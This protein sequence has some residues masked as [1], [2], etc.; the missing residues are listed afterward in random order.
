[1]CFSTNQ[2][3]SDVSNIETFAA[4]AARW[5]DKPSAAGHLHTFQPH[6]EVQNIPLCCFSF[7]IRTTTKKNKK[8]KSPKNENDDPSGFEGREPFFSVKNETTVIRFWFW[9]VFATEVTEFNIHADPEAASEVFARWGERFGGTKPSTFRSAILIGRGRGYIE[10]NL[11]GLVIFSGIWNLIIDLQIDNWKKHRCI[12]WFDT[13]NIR[14]MVGHGWSTRE[15]GTSK[16]RWNETEANS[17]KAFFAK[18]REDNSK[19][20]PFIWLRFRHS[21]SPHCSS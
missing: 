12:V 5:W 3:I 14:E 13:L 11:D 21:T 18:T 17:E 19:K 1:M 6:L 9:Y 2:G 15:T 20:S 7:S 10:C 16:Q 8:P 4:S